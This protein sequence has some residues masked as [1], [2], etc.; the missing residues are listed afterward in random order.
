[1]V[2]VTDYSVAAPA[3][4]TNR[5]V[6]PA[7]WNVPMTFNINATQHTLAPGESQD[8]YGYQKRTIEFHRG[9]D[10]GTQRYRLSGGEYTFK[11]T[12]RGWE[13]FKSPLAQ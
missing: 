13:L 12:E 6:N 5:I 2:Q 8:L 9:G 1:M 4:L 3:P 11:P 7:E 10:F